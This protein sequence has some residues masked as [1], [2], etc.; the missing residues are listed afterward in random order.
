LNTC[1]CTDSFWLSI[2]YEG[3]DGSDKGPPLA[4]KIVFTKTGG[5]TDKVVYVGPSG[6]E[7]DN[8]EWIPLV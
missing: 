8:G 6:V 5:V 7:Y 1:G 2:D 4:V 3:S